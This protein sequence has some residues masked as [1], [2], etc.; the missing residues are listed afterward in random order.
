MDETLATTTYSP[1]ESQEMLAH[2]ADH[3]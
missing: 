2:H 1:M 3:E